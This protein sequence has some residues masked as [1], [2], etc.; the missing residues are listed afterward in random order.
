MWQAILTTHT[1]NNP[2]TIRDENVGDPNPDPMAAWREAQAFYDKAREIE[3]E[4]TVLTINLRPSSYSPD[5]GGSG[6]DL[7]FK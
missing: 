5:S 1:G 2:A 6:V 3:P 4:G 7:V